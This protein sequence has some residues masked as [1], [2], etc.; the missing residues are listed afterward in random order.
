MLKCFSSCGTLS[1]LLFHPAACAWMAAF[2]LLRDYIKSEIHYCI[3]LNHY[4]TSYNNVVS[5]VVVVT[6]AVKCKNYFG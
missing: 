2:M 1:L 5:L 6:A 4:T 3:N